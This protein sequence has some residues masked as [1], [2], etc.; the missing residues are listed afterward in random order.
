MRTPNQSTV[1]AS[2]H[3]SAA[4]EAARAAT[5]IIRKAYRGNFSVE[6]KADASP[7]TEVDV[8]AER[9]IKAALRARFPDYGFYGEETGRDIAAGSEYLWL[10]DPIDGTKAFVRGY[11]IFSVQIALMRGSELIMGVSCA[12]CW[13]EGLGEVAWAERGAGAW[14]GLLETPLADYE[15]LR[16]STIDQLGKATLSTGNLATLARAPQWLELGRLIPQLHR[17]R[18]YGDFVHYH[19]LAAGKLDAVVESDVNIL[20]IAALAVIVEEAGGRF[21]DL[22]GRPPSLETRT[23]LATNGK[24]HE[25]FA[26]LAL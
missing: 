13:N 3:I 5:D 23:V 9:A 20:D 10:V 7:V 25:A 18:G 17:I 19:Y 24:L 11:P 12:P 15:R 2:P 14:R 26:G 4:L 16:V 8:A 1:M 21:T 22:N 6:Y